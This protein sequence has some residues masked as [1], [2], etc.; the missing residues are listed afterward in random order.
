MSLAI[1][2]TGDKIPT[3]GFGSGTK[4]QWKKKGN[5]NTAITADNLSNTDPDLVNST[6]EALETGFRHLDTAEIY[7]TRP[8]IGLGVNK[9]LQLH[10]EI[11]R[12]D[13]FITDKYHAISPHISNEL[14]NG[15]IRGPYVSLTTGLKLMNLDYIDLFLI[16]TVELPEGLSLEEAWKEMIQL[17]KE[18]LAKNIGV[19]NFDIPHLETV[20]NVD[21]DYPPQV[22]QLEFHPYLQNQSPNIFKF[23]KENNILI[24]GYGPLMPITKA[25]DEGPLIPLLNKLADKYNV[26]TSK[27]LLKWSLSHGVVAITTSSK[28]ER[29]IDSLQ[30]YD[31]QIDEEDLKEISKVG[32]THFYRAFAIKTLPQWDE[33]LKT[34]R[35]VDNK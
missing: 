29:L 20:I 6:I 2:R 24:E 32:N 11:K 31:F 21:K 7:T 17:Q 14:P 27:I 3:L 4:W 30:V 9:F 5:E 34:E 25:K 35:N 23:C 8:D 33:Q 19:S 26:T 10:P 18:G 13:L 28:K 15:K 22:L 16:H 12:N 1:P